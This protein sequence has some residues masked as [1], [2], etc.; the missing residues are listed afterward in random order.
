MEQY[1]VIVVGAGA[2]GM[3]AGYHAARAGRRTLLID[4]YDPPHAQGTHHGETRIIRHAYGE[5]RA[6]TP[7]ALRAQALWYELERETSRK[8]FLETGFLQAGEPGS[9]MLTEMQGSAKEH[10]LPVE[11][12]N[13]CE[14][15]RRWPGLA[16]PDS[17]VGCY[18]AGSGV[19]LSEACVQAYRDAA[20]AR[21]ATMLPN[22]PVIA[23]HPNK[24]GAEVVTASGKLYRAKSLIV[25]AGKFA[26]PMLAKLGLSQMPLSPLRK[27]VEWFKPLTE[28]YAPD[29]FPA[30]LFDLPEGIFFGF[31]DIGGEG[32][33]AGRHDGTIRPMPADGLLLPH[34]TFE[35]DGQDCAAY[36]ARY[37]PG[38]KP[39]I[40]KGSAC[41]YTMTPDE[42]FIL[43][44]HPDYPHIAIGAGFSGHGFKFASANGEILAKLAAGEDPGFDLSLFTLRRF[45][46]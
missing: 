8:L 19:L 23:I 4:A 28:D 45:N 25:T 15:K 12:L 22:T 7:M 34:G 41:T 10:R 42:H 46:P 3:S 37:M 39:E 17:F 40:I 27:T 14:I 33:K 38:I 26:G 43:D 18:E 9:Q 44:R 32:V 16:L 20:V 21:G 24:E 6:Y 30:F 36:I 13:G 2:M 5:G 35:D 1:D 31:P 29:T 11:V